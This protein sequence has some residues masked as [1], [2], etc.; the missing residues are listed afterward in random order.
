MGQ[1]SGKQLT[2]EGREILLKELIAESIKFNNIKFS[3]MCICVESCGCCQQSTELC[4]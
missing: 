4:S 2:V 1:N 3:W